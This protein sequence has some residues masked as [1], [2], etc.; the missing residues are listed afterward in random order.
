MTKRLNCPMC[1]KGEIKEH[2][3]DR[4]GW[5]DVMGKNLAKVTKS[6]EL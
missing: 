4:C 3:C 1:R 6:G 2:V 5:T